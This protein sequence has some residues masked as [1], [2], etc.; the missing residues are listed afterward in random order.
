LRFYPGTEPGR[1][2]SG[3]AETFE[4]ARD[5]FERAWEAFLPTRTEADFQAWRDQQAWTREKY[6]RREENRG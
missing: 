2:R 6:A 4:Q 1:Y 3:N 5:A